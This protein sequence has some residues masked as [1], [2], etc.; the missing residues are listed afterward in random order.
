[1]FISSFVKECSVEVSVNVHDLFHP[2]VVETIIRQ[3]LFVCALKMTLLNIEHYSIDLT[4]CWKQLRQ[5]EY[6]D[7]E[8]R[9]LLF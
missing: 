5:R 3:G 9:M 2:S 8:L 6:I 4:E 1:M 7:F